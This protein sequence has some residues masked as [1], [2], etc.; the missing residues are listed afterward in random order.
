MRK[1]QWQLVAA[2][3]MV[4]S[5][6]GATAAKAQAATA[7]ATQSVKDDLFAGTEKFAQGATRV[8]QIDMDPDS[9]DMVGGAHGTRAHQTI[10]NVVHSYTYDKPGMYKME[11]VEEFRR[12]LN[13]GDW[14]CS[15]RV[16]EMKTGESTDVC[17]RHRTD[18]L[19]ES[20]IIT[21]QPTSLTFIHTI[22]KKGAPGQGEMSGFVLGT[23]DGLPKLA[24]LDADL[25]GLRVSL[26]DLHMPEMRV[27]IEA[28]MNAREAVDGPAMRKRIEDAMRKMEDAQKRM[29]DMQT[30][31]A[32]SKPAA[33]APAPR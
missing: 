31:E 32:P 6:A 10:L 20:A 14:H 23:L 29:K 9:L 16:R 28:A 15:V 27:E 24:M 33:P 8:T 26:G 22:R 12:K 25:A 21:V 18:D 7:G 30:P 13:T 17:Q 3:A 5:M 1:I 19:V 2:M 11:D 4:C